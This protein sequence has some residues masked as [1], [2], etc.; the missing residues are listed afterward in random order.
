MKPRRVCGVL[1]AT[2]E[3]YEVLDQ[4]GARFRSVFCGGARSL[5]FGFEFRR[6]GC[7]STGLMPMGPGLLSS[8]PRRFPFEL[9]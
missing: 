2:V 6:G 1:G 8:S 9:I 3:Q 5:A 4:L 7:T